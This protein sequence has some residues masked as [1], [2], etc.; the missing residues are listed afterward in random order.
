MHGFT[1]KNIEI[2]YIIRKFFKIKI[3]KLLKEDIAYLL[4]N[5]DADPAIY[6]TCYIVTCKIISSDFKYIFFQNLS[7]FQLKH[8]IIY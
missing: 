8:L 4:H 6:A 3:L 7:S 1:C 2:L 5:E